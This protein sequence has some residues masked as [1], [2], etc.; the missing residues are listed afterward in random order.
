MRLITAGTL[1]G[2]HP[3][4]IISP[5]ELARCLFPKPQQI[6]RRKAALK[7]CLP[8]TRAWPASDRHPG[9]RYLAEVSHSR[10]MLPMY[11]HPLT[12]LE[13]AVLCPTL[14]PKLATLPN[15]IIQPHELH[16][17]LLAIQD[18]RPARK[19]KWTVGFN[20]TPQF[21]IRV[22]GAG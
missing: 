22:G 5:A 4:C 21:K 3:F 9:W 1:Q 2:L 7:E 15:T 17:F 19:R 6:K 16:P 10:P 13:L 8:L 20:N 14:R 11:P 18:W 12:L